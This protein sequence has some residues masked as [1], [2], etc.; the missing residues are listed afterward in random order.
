[1]TARQFRRAVCLALLAVGVG[2]LIYL[3]ETR[4][5]HVSHRLMQNPASTMMR[6]VGLAHFLVGWL[7]LLT[8][9][10]LRSR[11]ALGRLGAVTGLGAALCLFCG[12]SGF[13]H[14]PL[15]FVFFYGYFLTH[16]VLD[17]ATLF[18][19]YGE[20]GTGCDEVRAVVRLLAW[21][22][23]LLMTATLAG[24]YLLYGLIGPRDF[25]AT[26]PTACLVVGMLGTA[27]GGIWLGKRVLGPGRQI[28][29]SNADFLHAHR[30]LLLVYASLF[31]I[32][33]LGCVC[34]SVVFNLIILIHAGSWL[35]F[36]RR[37]LSARRVAPGRRPWTWLRYT[38]TG[39]LVLHL[40]AVVLV[41]VLMALRVYVWDR[42]GPFCQALANSSFPYWSLMHISTAFWRPR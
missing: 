39:F 40:G 5:L 18:Q 1:L 9:P 33:L 6:A 14:S 7:F 20:L 30:P 28:Y 41:L 35:L 17:E 12:L 4:L 11:A 37:Q 13:A 23:A 24:G 31:V 3:V 16:E 25:L 2:G 21:A 42:S 22:V 32:L 19:G 15:M 38:P 8:S 10:R 27:A 26:G 29:G 36:V 34:G